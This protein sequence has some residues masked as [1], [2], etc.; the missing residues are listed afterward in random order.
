MA[1]F[2][3]T[4]RIHATLHYS[5]CTN[6]PEYGADYQVSIVTVKKQPKERRKCVKKGGRT[7]ALQGRTY[8]TTT[9]AW[10]LSH[11]NWFNYKIKR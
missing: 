5:H 2:S 4:P 7:M 10:N 1:I 11:C 8:Y 3:L 6:E 9:P